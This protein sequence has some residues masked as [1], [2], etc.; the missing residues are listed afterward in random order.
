MA[1]ED[2]IVVITT[3]FQAF[4]VVGDV[5]G[6]DQREEIRALAALLYAG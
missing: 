6:P 2:Q 4:L 1:A 5:L 3:A